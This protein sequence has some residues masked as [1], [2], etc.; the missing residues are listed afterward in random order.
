MSPEFLI[1][2]FLQKYFLCYCD[3]LQIKI[4]TKILTKGRYGMWLV[5]AS[6]HNN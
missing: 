6:L 2:L 5:V 1:K 3:H 4:I